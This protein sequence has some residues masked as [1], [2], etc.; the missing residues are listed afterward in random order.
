MEKT[1]GLLLLSVSDEAGVYI[2]ATPQGERVF[3]TGHSEY[4]GDT[5]K[6]EYLRDQ[7]AGLD[8]PLPVNYFPEDDPTREP[9]VTWRSHANLLYSNWLNYYVYQTTPYDIST[10][11]F[12]KKNTRSALLRGF[13]AMNVSRRSSSR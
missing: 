12:W 4:D 3:V 5:L 2:A 10:I 7:A 11:S 1:E 8:T 9:N 13:F 6:N